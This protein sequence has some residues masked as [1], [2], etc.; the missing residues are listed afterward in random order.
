MTIH[1]QGEPREKASLETFVKL[2]RATNSVF[3]RV[4]RVIR[5]YGLTEPQF[6][7][8]EMLFHLGPLE[9]HTIARK[10]LRTGGNITYLIDRLETAGYVERGGRDG[11]RRCNVVRL[12]RSG[13]SLMKKIFP[14]HVVKMMEIFSSLSL[15]EQKELS[16]LCKKLGTSLS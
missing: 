4:S 12:T 16:R 10:Q 9:Q 11:D 2:M 8:L 14:G 3:N 13:N 6:A 5:A 15:S 1:Y 7:V